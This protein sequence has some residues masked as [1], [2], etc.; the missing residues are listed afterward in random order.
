MRSLTSPLRRHF[1][2]HDPAPV[3]SRLRQPVLA[4]YGSLDVQA[5]PAQKQ[6]VIERALG[7][8]RTL[9]HT[10]TEIRG[11]NHRMPPAQTGSPRPIEHPRIDTAL[12]PQ[13]LQ[14]VGDWVSRRAA[15]T[16]R[17]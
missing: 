3:L 13:L 6:P 11:M 5:P 2:A 14:Q 17:G 8:G 7:A 9:D 16:H 15:L 1:L 10:V 12:D 4:I